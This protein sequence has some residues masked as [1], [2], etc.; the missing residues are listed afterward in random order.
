[1]G[2]FVWTEPIAQE[3][4]RMVDLGM[5]PMDAIKSATSVSAEMLDQKDELGVVAPQALADLVAVKGDPL[6]DI[7]E[8]ER[9]VFVM[10]GGDVFKNTLGGAPNAKN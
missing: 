5:P 2:G 10:K 7:T 1:V 4:K 3:F 8:L 6:Q 9:V